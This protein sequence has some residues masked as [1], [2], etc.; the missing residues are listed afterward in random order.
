MSIHDDLEVWQANQ[1]NLGRTIEVILPACI[2]CG[3]SCMQRDFGFDLK[4]IDIYV[5]SSIIFGYL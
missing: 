5:I 4:Q 3:E 1:E 2:F